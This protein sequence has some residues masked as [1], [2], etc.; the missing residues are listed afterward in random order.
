MLAN[1]LWITWLIPSKVPALIFFFFGGMGPN[2][3]TA[4]TL[5]GTVPILPPIPSCRK[6]SCPLLSILSLGEENS[7]SSCGS[8]AEEE[9]RKGP[10]GWESILGGP[11][12]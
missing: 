12:S 10:L 7:C 9:G 11:M 2:T 5:L 4:V 6:E 8:E 1:G 3:R